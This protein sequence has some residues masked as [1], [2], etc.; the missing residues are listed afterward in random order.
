MPIG[1]EGDRS[2]SQ[3][4]DL[5][6]LDAFEDRAEVAHHDREVLDTGVC[7]NEIVFLFLGFVAEMQEFG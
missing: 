4:L 7:V 6:F 1:A 3:Q 2:L 5:V